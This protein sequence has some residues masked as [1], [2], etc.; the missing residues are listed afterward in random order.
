M[1]PQARSGTGRCGSLVL[2]RP[3]GVLRCKAVVLGLH[4]PVVDR[5]PPAL[6]DAAAPRRDAPAQERGRHGLAAPAAGDGDRGLVECLDDELHRPSG[7]AGRDHG[8]TGRGVEPLDRRARGIRE[9]AEGAGPRLGRGRAVQPRRP[10][11]RHRRAEVRPACGRR[12]ASRCATCT[13]RRRRSWPSASSEGARAVVSLEPDGAVRRWTCELCGD[14]DVARG[15]RGARACV[16]REGPSPRR[17][18]RATS[19]EAPWEAERGKFSAQA[20]LLPRSPT[21]R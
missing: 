4:E 18:E 10:L 21:A 17:S 7:R 20:A 8:S 13:G 9:R 3:A 11:A 16:A 2:A 19:A 1:P 5:R 12:T 15:A 14:L 6:D